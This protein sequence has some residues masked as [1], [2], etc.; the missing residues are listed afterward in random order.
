MLE[1]EKAS[2]DVAGQSRLDQIRAS[3]SGQLPASQQAPATPV[4]ATPETPPA[5]GTAEKS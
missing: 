1:V 5:E 2:L 3:M 4:A